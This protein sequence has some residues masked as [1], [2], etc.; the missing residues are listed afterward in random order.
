MPTTVT[1]KTMTSKP[2]LYNSIHN[3]PLGRFIDVLIDGEIALL[4]ISGEPTE[5]ELAQA[6]NEIM[7]QY[8][9][10]MGSAEN[11]LLISLYK[12]VER[13][14]I[15]LNTILSLIDNLRSW[16]VKAWCDRLNELSYTRF[17]F[18]I[19]VI[20]AYQ[21]NLDSCATRSKA[22]EVQIELKSATIASMEASKEGETFK[23]TREYFF[24]IL[25]NLSDHAGH[26]ISEEIGVLKFCLRVKRY[27]EY[28]KK[29]ET[30][31]RK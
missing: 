16:Y 5:T 29:L 15:R 11:Q 8:N 26:E 6:W 12:G 22:L 2:K 3:L 7:E 24:Q 30:S 19:S 20:D 31:K 27:I 14:R 25:L 1:K 28:C 17:P 21:G 18:D 9:E 23:P 13:T 4:I 10:A